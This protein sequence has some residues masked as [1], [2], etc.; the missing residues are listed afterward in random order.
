M[1]NEMSR[2]SNRS[3]PISDSDLAK[4][5]AGT[6]PGYTDYDWMKNMMNKWVTSNTTTF[7]ASGGNEGI[8]FFSSFGFNNDQGYFKINENE[9][10]KRYTFRTN[11]DAKIAKGLSTRLSFYGRYENQV[12]PI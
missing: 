10:Y 4:W 9:Q 2:N 3:L 7:N 6:E 1:N 11:V 8:R 12:Q 5:K